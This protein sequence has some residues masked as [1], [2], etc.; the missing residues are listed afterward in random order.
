MD[1]YITASAVNLQNP[2]ANDKWTY[3]NRGVYDS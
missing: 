3:I 1:N 2:I